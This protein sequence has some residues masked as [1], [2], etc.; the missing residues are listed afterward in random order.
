LAL[1]LLFLECRKIPAQRVAAGETG[2]NRVG[3][4]KGN[5]PMII[6]TKPKEIFFNRH[7]TL[8]VCLL[9]IFATLLLYWQVTQHEFIRFD[10]DEYVTKNHHV[11]A[12]LTSEG[13]NWSFSFRDRTTYWHPLTWLSHMLDCQLY[14]LKPRGHHLTN[15]L[16]HLANSLLLFL[17]LKRMTGAFW[18]S[19][20]V[21]ALFALHPLN[22]ESVA[23]TAERKNVLSTFFWMLTLLTY[24]HY[25][26]RPTL[27]RYLLITIVFALGLMA[28][29]MLVTLP[30]VL[31]LLD[32]W[33]LGRLRLGRLEG[34][35]EKETAG[36]V[37][38][39]SQRKSYLRLVLEKLPLLALS[40]L[41]IYIFSL[42]VQQSGT[43]IS[44]Q[45]VPMKLRISNGLVSYLSYICKTIWP[46][47]LAFFYP[48]PSM[49]PIWQTVTAGCLLVGVSV[50]VLRAWKKI[51]YLVTGWLWYLGT[52]V[53][54][55]GLKQAGLWPAMA[56]RWAYIPLIGIFI[57]ITW[58]I[59]D[60]IAPWRHEKTALP[61]AAATAIFLSAVC[62]RVQLQHW[63]NSF[64]LF[65]HAL[66]VTENNHVAHNNFGFILTQQ[67]KIHEATAQ[68]T[69]A[70][71]IKPDY[72]EAHYNLGSALAQRGH[73]Q[74]AIAR[75]SK[76]L[77]IKPDYAE[78]HNN[79][80][81]V[82]EQQGKLKT[83]EY[84]FY[85]ALEF[86]P[87]VSEIHFNLGNT[88]ARQGKL[89][90]AM[91]HYLTALRLNPNYPQAYNNLGNILL[92]EGR[93]ADAI[94]RYSKA[95]Q[96]APD[97]AE[98]HNN[99]GVALFRQGRNK[100]AI[101]HILEAL[102]L[103]PDYPQARAN[104]SIALQVADKTTEAPSSSSI[105]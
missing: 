71:E 43:A 76:A 85:R 48:Y 64:T 9:L 49:V 45:S 53:P 22:V 26:E 47:N 57:I 72:A 51:P 33:P 5:S 88:L 90:E 38:T 62:T 82:L 91:V 36:S 46:Q 83:A 50:L 35:R 16:F 95:L 2:D 13:I 21:A 94:G 12:G 41:S 24:V 81:N 34:D 69:R 8:L 23:W 1:F 75:L 32:H 54:V 42:S 44:M 80:G 100:E 55:L 101:A 29:P 78:A 52:L 73:T 105:P 102:R 7:R 11:Q 79:L 3:L 31:L 30:F 40:V 58:G 4:L 19:A 70:L 96:L 77:E 37:I 86:E 39:G 89:D 17:I 87:D 63:Q 66:K 92:Q 68:F 18:R 60:L 15:L 27:Y 20:F 59:P 61:I 98:A 97:Y 6:V 74:E 28:K 104:L 56:D 10:D 103:E 65:A 25:A 84:H 14:G 93:L 67:G 99:M